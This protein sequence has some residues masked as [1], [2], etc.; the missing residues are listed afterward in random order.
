VQLRQTNR[1]VSH[2]GDDYVCVLVHNA[3]SRS[4][5]LRSVPSPNQLGR[6]NAQ[7]RLILEGGGKGHPSQKHFVF[8]TATI[9]YRQF[10]A[11]DSNMEDH[12][13]EQ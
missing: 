3:E 4:S 2:H 6:P 8:M 5:A 11:Q 9:Q 1:D 12:I 10:K 13:R 7:R